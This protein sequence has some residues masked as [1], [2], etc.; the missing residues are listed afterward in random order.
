[1]AIL[2]G[3]AAL[4][5][6]NGG[7]NKKH[8][9]TSLKSGTTLKVRVKGLTRSGLTDIATYFGYGIYKQVDTFVPK[10][11]PIRD[12]RGFVTANH[13][14]WDLAS[15]YFYELGFKAEDAG[16]SEAEVKKLKESGY[17]YKGK[18]RVMVGLYDLTSGK[19]IVIDVS[20]KQHSA[21]KNSLIDYLEDDQYKEMA[22]KISK[23]GDGTDTVVTVTP[24]INVAKGLTDEEKENF[25]ASADEPFNDA[26][27]DGILYEA[28]DAEQIEFLQKDGF[29]VGLIG[30]S[31][32]TKADAGPTSAE[33]SEKDEPADISDDDLPF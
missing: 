2:K 6:L 29:D 10:N 31:G 13:S 24:I 33:I 14:P 28:D 17:R 1:M 7:G 20:P 12:A 26:I 4:E 5:D 22:F 25:E 21:I 9:F 23:K 3:N 27:F 19:D 18:K 8:S 32:A 11:D 15:K 30:L 16:K